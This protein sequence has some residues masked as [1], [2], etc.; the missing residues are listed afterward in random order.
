MNNKYSNSTPKRIETWNNNNI[1]KTLI[2]E[3]RYQT[4]NK[5][6]DNLSDIKKYVNENY[7]FKKQWWKICKCWYVPNWMKWK[8]INEYLVEADTIEGLW[9]DKQWIYFTYRN[10]IK[11][12]KKYIV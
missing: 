4:S 11:K 12:G 3:T 6:I 7:Y 9:K 2:T 8:N 1:Q 5:L 10:W